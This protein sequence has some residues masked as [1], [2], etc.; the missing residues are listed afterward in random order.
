MMKT[1]IG[2]YFFCMMLFN[3]WFNVFSGSFLYD[4]L[5]SAAEVSGQIEKV[6]DG[7]MKNA[8]ME[9]NCDQR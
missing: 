8:G 6:K 7:R 5:T 9:N 1:A 3:Y 4:L 2:I